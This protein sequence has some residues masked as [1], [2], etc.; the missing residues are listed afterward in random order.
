MFL[1]LNSGSMKLCAAK[2]SA[3]QPRFGQIATFA[4]GTW[5]NF[6]SIVACGTS[7]NCSLRPIFLT[8]SW[9]ASAV[10]F[11]GDS[12]SATVSSGGPVY[13]PFL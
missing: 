9:N 8:C 13:L 5:Q 12:L 10:S 1:P 3:P 2:K 7:R 11:A 4:F 6:V